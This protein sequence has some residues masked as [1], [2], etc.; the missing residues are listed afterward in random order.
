MK[1]ALVQ[2]MAVGLVGLLSQIASCSSS[3]SENASTRVL[4][5]GNSYTFFNSMPEIFVNVSAALSTSRPTTILMLAPGGSA[6]FEHG[7]LSSAMGQATAAALSDPLGW[8]FVVLQDQSEVPGGGKDTDANLP[9][10]AGRNL[11]LAALQAFFKPRIADAGAVPVLYSTWGRHD[12][13]PPNAECCRYANFLQMNQETTFGYEMYAQTLSPELSGD[14]RGG[15]TTGVDRSNGD[16]D[17]DGAASTTNQ[18]YYYGAAKRPLVAPAGHAWEIVFNASGPE[19]LGNHS[20]FSCLYNHGVTSENDDANA[21]AYNA[22]SCVLDS[23]GMGG[24]PSLEGSYLI[25][26]VM[27]ATIHKQSVLHLPWAPEGMS[28]SDAIFLQGVAEQAVTMAPHR[29]AM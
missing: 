18:R 5:V 11:T 6:L 4:F 16:D 12:G 8:D 15:G 29:S 19:P 2:L 20:R 14:E 21:N 24:H 22:S 25:A 1:C 9:P 26:L 23:A 13:D 17:G 27:A 7:N 10:R 3:R 28:A